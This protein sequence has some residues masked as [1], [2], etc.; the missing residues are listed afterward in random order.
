LDA[1]LSGQSQNA[2]DLFLRVYYM[3]EKCK[4]ARRF[5]YL[6]RHYSDEIESTIKA[7]LVRKKLPEKVSSEE[8]TENTVEI[9]QLPEKSNHKSNF[10]LWIF[11]LI[12][13]VVAIYVMMDGTLK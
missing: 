2:S 3:D 4:D 7:S 5:L 1:L 9:E 6:S 8:L 11:L 10:L 12:L 13:I